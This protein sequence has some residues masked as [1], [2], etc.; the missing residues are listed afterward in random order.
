MVARAERPS[1]ENDAV[2]KMT[3]GRRS[4]P[5]GAPLTGCR[6]SKSPGSSPRGMELAFRCTA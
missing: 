5:F 4:M 2:E 1:Q 3:H 6:F